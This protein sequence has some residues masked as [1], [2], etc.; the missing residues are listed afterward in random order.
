M[1]ELDLF[2]EFR[3]GVAAPSRDAERRALA[4]LTS[5]IEGQHRRGA[6]PRPILQRRGRTVLA[7]A[8]LAGATAAALFVSAPWKSSPGFLERAQAALAPPAGTVLHQTWEWTTSTA[9]PSCKV[10]NGPNETWIDQ[11]PPHRYRGLMVWSRDPCARG[12]STEG[13]GAID[14]QER[15]EFVPP[16]TLRSGGL[17]GYFGPPDPVAALRRAISDGRAHDEGTT[18]L[19]G[20]TVR[21]IRVDGPNGPTDC[22]VR[23]CEPAYQY[24]DP[25]TYY[26]VQ[27]ESSDGVAIPS[28]GEPPVRFHEV[29]RWLTYE[30]LPGTPANRALADIR[31]QHPNASG[32]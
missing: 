32:P 20:R 21:R 23:G 31:A 18:E 13:G 30:Y 24:V 26:P 8:A 9:D 17:G 28:P 22:P 12:T 2:R 16:N 19:G 4:R 10:T 29:I 15:L 27:W 25:E 14:T 3:S 7:F 11:T 6:V 5:A 1:D